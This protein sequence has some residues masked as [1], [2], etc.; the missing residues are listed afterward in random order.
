MTTAYEWYSH[1]LVHERAG[2]S[3][4]AL[5]AFKNSLRIN[6]HVAAP[7]VAL[8]R[9]FKANLQ[10][11]DAMQCLQRAVQCE[12]ENAQLRTFLGRSLADLGEVEVA[13]RSFEQ[14][15]QLA[16]QHLEA[17]LGLAA[18][19]ED[20]GAASTAA[21]HYRQVLIHQP[22]HP[23]ALSALL[24]LGKYIEIDTELSI[25]R[26]LLQ[27]PALANETVALL[28]YGAGKE[29]ERRADY[30]AAFNY[31]RRAN[32]ARREAVGPFDRKAFTRRI[33]RLCEIFS[34]EFLQHRAD[35]G[36][37]SDEPVFIV[38]LPR[39]GTTLTEQILASHPQ[40]Y[41]AG[42]IDA[43]ADLATALPDRLGKRDTA[44]PSAAL[45]ASAAHLQQLGQDYLQRLR[46][47][48][49]DWWHWPY[50]VPVSFIA[51][52]IRAT[53]AWQYSARTFL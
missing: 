37:Q 41:G 40:V 34:A 36:A 38:G 3:E 14:A 6:S 21:H 11:R 18:L 4:E 15:L 13:Q 8:A 45:L 2:R 1:G 32:Q 51:Y 16:P 24:H 26:D 47:R 53:M 7:Y 29:L 28:A 22:H 5:V 25:V 10:K 43:L 42:E 33:D 20:K 39:S 27:D 31:Y 12:P 44:W 17:S 30:S 49:P 52:E 9:L 46:Y 50:R 35:W 19:Y 48:Q 23:Q